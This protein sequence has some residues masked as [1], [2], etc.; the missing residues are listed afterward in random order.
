MLSYMDSLNKIKIFK[1]FLNAEEYNHVLNELFHNGQW[2]FGW[3]S[4]YNNK[5]MPPFWRRDL[6]DDAY[7][8]EYLKNKIE[9]VCGKRFHCRRVYANAKTYGQDGDYHTDGENDED[10][11]IEYTFCLYITPL[12]NNEKNVIGGELQFKLP[13]LD[14]EIYELN[15]L[16]HPNLGVLFPAHFKH[17][18]MAYKRYTHELRICIAWKL[19]EIK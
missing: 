15:V 2:E 6:Y 13:E 11:I 8:S 17:R 7:Y 9:Q 4:D 14:D 12:K 16:C 5:C 18:G 1:S 19:K 10:N 3:R